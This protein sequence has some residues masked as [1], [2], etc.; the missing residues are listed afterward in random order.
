MSVS[1]PMSIVKGGINLA[2]PATRDRDG[3][4]G[5]SKSHI[6]LANTASRQYVASLNFI[7]QLNQDSSLKYSLNASAGGVSGEDSIGMDVKYEVFF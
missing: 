1:S 3:N 6:N 7:D 2:V 5:Y 4:L